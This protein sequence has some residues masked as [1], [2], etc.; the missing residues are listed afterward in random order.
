MG[1]Y[2]PPMEVTGP[3][4]AVTGTNSTFFGA[5]KIPLIVGFLLLVAV[6]VVLGYFLAFRDIENKDVSL[7]RRQTVVSALPYIAGSDNERLIEAGNKLVQMKG[8]ETDADALYVITV[9]DIAKSDAENGQKHVRLL[10][11][12]KA[13]DGFQQEKIKTYEKYRS[14]SGL[15]DEIKFL[16]MANRQGGGS[17]GQ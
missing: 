16:K 8:Y 10:E 12:A 4:K 14:V 17:G 11:A 3:K 13:K 6:V 2:E 5:R 15:S 1:V 7:D 9:A